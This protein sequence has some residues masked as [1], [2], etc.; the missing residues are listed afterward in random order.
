MFVLIPMIWG[1][2]VIMAVFS[3]I[4]AIIGGKPAGRNRRT[5]RRPVSDDGHAVSF[6]QDLTC[7]TKYGHDHST[8][9][10]RRYIVHED[11]EEGYVVLNGVKRKIRDCKYL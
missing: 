4:S 5:Q 3:I 7:E 11:P 2:L 1:F 8:P 10:G 6:D 9:G